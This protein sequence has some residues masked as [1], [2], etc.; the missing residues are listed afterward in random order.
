MFNLG[1]ITRIFNSHTGATTMSHGFT[2]FFRSNGF[3]HVSSIYMIEN[4]KEG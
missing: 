4:N 2:Y 3:S 1:I